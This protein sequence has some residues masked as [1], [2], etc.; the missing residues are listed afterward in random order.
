MPEWPEMEHYRKQLTRM[1]LNM[2]IRQVIVNRPKSL[3]VTEEN[4]RQAILGAAIRRVERR[5]KQLIF[6]LDTDKYLLLHLM[7]GGILFYGPERDRPD[8]S[9]QIEL[10]F[11]DNRLYFIGLRLG[12]LHLF[13]RSGLEKELSDLGPDPFDAALSPDRFLSMLH[14]K[15]GTLKT[16]LTDQKWLAGIGNCY[17]DEICFAAGLLPTRG[18]G[19]LNQQEGQRLYTAM[20]SVL[21]EALAAGG[22]MEMPLFNGD[23]LTGSYNDLCKVYDRPGDPCVRC[24]QPI[25]FDK[26]SSRKCF[27]CTNCQS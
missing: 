27:Y 26:V 19:S 15:K 11:G 25:V 16:T 8:R 14:G 10:S 21:N 18:P 23:K 3:N 1:I 7:L 22:Y 6:V 20:H 2:P 13:D 17:S 5:A 4:F 9:T 12:Y 24:G